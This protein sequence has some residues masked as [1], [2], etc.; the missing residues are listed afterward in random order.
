MHTYLRTIQRI[1]EQLQEQ[2]ESY[3]QGTD[4]YRAYIDALQVIIE[5][6]LSVRH[7]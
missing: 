2:A 6:G 4:E 5:A 3:E 7:A 1:L